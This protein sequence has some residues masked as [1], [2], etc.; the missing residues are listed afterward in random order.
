MVPLAFAADTVEVKA[1]KKDM[2]QDVILLI[3][4]IIECNHWNSEESTNKDRIAEIKNA[5]DKF[6]CDAL[7]KDYEAL[8]K[9]YQNNYEIKSRLQAAEQIF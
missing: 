1:L 2:P 6:G 9:R 8:R 5:R 3:D 7:P 4:R